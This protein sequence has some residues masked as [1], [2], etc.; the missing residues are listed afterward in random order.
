MRASYLACRDKE[1]VCEV[2]YSGFAQWGKFGDEEEVVWT[3]RFANKRE[4]EVGLVYVHRHGKR[5]SPLF[6]TS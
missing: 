4:G 6:A 5:C 3:K 2:Q 1:C